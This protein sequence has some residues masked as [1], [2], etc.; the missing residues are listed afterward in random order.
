MDKEDKYLTCKIN[1]LQFNR[2]PNYV[3]KGSAPMVQL[4]IDM[5]QDGPEHPL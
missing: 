2:H 5:D 1:D 3:F 4:A